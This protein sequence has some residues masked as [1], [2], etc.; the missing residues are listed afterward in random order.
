MVYSDNDHNGGVSN[1]S[2]NGMVRVIMIT[3]MMMMM[4]MMMVVMW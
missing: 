2:D 1:E 3:V 4:M